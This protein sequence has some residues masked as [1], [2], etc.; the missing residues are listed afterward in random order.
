MA[1]PESIKQMR[2]VVYGLRRCDAGDELEPCAFYDAHTDRLYTHCCKCDDTTD[3][4]CANKRRRGFRK[5]PKN[6]RRCCE[7]MLNDIFDAVDK[8]YEDK[9]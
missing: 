8:C 5:C 1:F 2:D 4:V 6:K 9:E 3:V 7:D